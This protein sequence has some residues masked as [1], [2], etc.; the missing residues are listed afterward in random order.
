[1]PLRTYVL[2]PGA[3]HGGWAWR[4]VAERL[5]AAGHRAVTLTLPGL[6]DG[7]DPTGLRLSDAVD[8]VVNKVEGLDHTDV[9]LV[10]HSWGGYPMTG[11]AHRLGGRVAELVYYNAFVPR[12]GVSLL[13]ENP[14]ENVA[15]LRS[16]MES[17]PTGSVPM[18]LEFV[19]QMLMQD[20]AEAAQRQLAEL[21]TPQPGGYWEDALDIPEV[22]ELGVPGRYILSED[23]RALPR[24][25]AEFAAR[26]GVEPVMVPGT[27]ESL[28]THPDEVA[29]ALLDD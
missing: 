20:V 10:S 15:L 3:W 16:L 8:H 26:L 12:P 13:G 18:A 4:P 14:P 19:Q 1:M 29:K 23:D 28:L 17:S 24:P 2:I 21:L 25:G 7:D 6:A 27:H 9:V 5:R 22:T 11:A